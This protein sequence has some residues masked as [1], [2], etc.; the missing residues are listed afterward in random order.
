M[1]KQQEDSYLKRLKEALKNLRSAEIYESKRDV[2][3]DKEMERFLKKCPNEKDLVQ[4]IKIIYQDLISG[5]YTYFQ[6]NGEN[7][8]AIL[9]FLIKCLSNKTLEGFLAATF[10][11]HQLTEKILFFLL[12]SQRFHMKLSVFPKTIHYKPLDS[13]KDNFF[14]MLRKL[15]ETIW[16]DGLEKMLDAAK[17]INEIRNKIGHHIL[18]QPNLQVIKNDTETLCTHFTEF[19]SLF[20]SHLSMLD[21]SQ[22]DTVDDFIEK[23]REFMDSL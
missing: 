20:E 10:I 23:S 11:C 17:N 12:E 3:F 6:L 8:K 14:P 9:D 22:P 5:K 1:T 13:K 18:K 21:A 15:E 16:F 19:L 4:D 2:A 7:Y